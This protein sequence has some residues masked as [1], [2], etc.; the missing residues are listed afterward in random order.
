MDHFDYRDGELCAE[1][2]ALGETRRALRH[3]VLRLL[4]GHPGAPLAR[5]RS[6]LRRSSA[7]DLFRRQGQLQSRR[8]QHPGPTRLRA[9]TS[10]RSVSWN[11]YWPP[12]VT[13]PRWSFPG[14]AS[15]PTRWRSRSRSAFAAS[16]SNPTAELERLDRVAGELG[17]HAP[18]SLRVNPDVDARHTS[19]HLHRSARKQVRHR[20][21]RGARHAYRRAAE[22]AN[23][24]VSRHRLPHRLAA[25]RG[26]AVPRRTA[27]HPRPWSSGW[28]DE[29]IALRHLDLGGG[30]G[31]PYSDERPPPTPDVYARA[32]ME[33]LSGRPLELLL[34]PGRAIA[35]NAGVLLTRVEYLKHP[36]H[37]NFAIVDAAM[38]DLQRPALYGLARYPAGRTAHRR[39]EVYDIVGPVCETGD[40]L[41]QRKSCRSPQ[42]T[43]SQCAPPVP[44]ALP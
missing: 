42:A 16:T 34:E 5:L 26:C 36:A 23:L 17:K 32:L 3:P 18:V 30:L 27:T 43:C 38:N 2:V 6:G 44:T 4:P 40:F 28:P 31:I 13:R 11:G 15:V 29:G 12:V 25:D 37:R 14:S 20:C 24:E 21:R 33:Q 1:G 7:P 41:A 10:S 35:G 39:A 8:V 22:L 19:L 9:S